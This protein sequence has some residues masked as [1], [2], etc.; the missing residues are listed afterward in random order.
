M[1][2]NDIAVVISRKLNQDGNIRATEN[3]FQGVYHIIYKEDD[4]NLIQTLKDFR[5]V[6]FSGFD[7]TLKDV[8]RELHESR[9]KT[10]VL[11]HYGAAREL[12]DEVSKAW[13]AVVSLLHEK[14]FDLFITCKKGQEEMVSSIFR[15]PT[16]FLTNN[17]K[18]GEFAD[19]KKHGI[20]VLGDSSEHWAK[21]FLPNMYAALMTGKEVNVIPYNS[22]SDKVVRKLRMESQVIEVERPLE[23]EKR[24]KIMAGCELI[25][26]VTLTESAS[27]TPLEALNNRV[28]YITGNTHHF[29]ED[30]YRLHELLVCTQPD[31]PNAIYEVIQRALENKTEIFTRYDIWKKRFDEFQEDNFDLFLKTMNLL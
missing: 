22:I 26:D 23:P 18:G 9:R 1:Y 25:T 7:E 30:D 2:A 8:A 27:V 14:V 4:D 3:M 20:G 17:S 13:Q 5:T 11:W 15:T 29:Y 19:V 28:L 31:N 16:F 6:L 21:N 12:D 10:A 24:M